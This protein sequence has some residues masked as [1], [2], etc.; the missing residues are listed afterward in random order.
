MK[1]LWNDQ[2]AAKF[3]GDL[4]LRVYTSRLLGRDKSLVLHGGGN[5]SV[6]IREKNLFGEQETILYVKGSGW[7]LET[8]EPQGFS[9]VLLA[10]VLRLAGL[11]SLSDP[12]MVNQLVTHMLKASAPAPSIETILHG[13]MPQKFVDHTHA[14]A[15]LSVSNT[16]DGE[17]RIREVYGKRCV[18]IPYLMPG[19]DLAQLCAKEFKRQSTPETVGMVLLN[20]GIFSFGETAREAYERM[21]ELV[22]LAEKYLESRGAWS[23]PLNPSSHSA[24]GAAAQ[25]GLRRRLSDAAC[26][27]LIVRTATNER[28][29]GLAAHPELARI[30]QQGPATP[31]HVIRTKR[32]PMLGTDIAAYV[33]EY[34]RYFNEHSPKAKEPKT[35]L[36]P[37]PRV[38]LDPAF[39]LAAAG[40]TAKDAAIVAEI[41]DHTIDVILRAEALGG[42]Q[43]LPAKDIFDV[44]YWDLEQ[45]KLKKGGTPPAFAGE[46]ALVTG[47]ASGIGK[48]TVAAFLARGAA[49]VG[50]DLNAGIES[51]HSRAD[52]LG[53]RCDV[54]DES[55]VRSALE[56]AVLAFGGLDM[57]VLNAGVF[58]ASRRIADLPTEEWRRAMTVN[59]DANLV[60]MRACHPFLKLAPRGGRVVVI[61]SKNVSAPGP[62]ASAYSASKAALNQLARIAALEWGADRIR[63]NTVHPNAVFDTGLWTEEVLVQRAKQY[64]MSVAAYK[65]NNVLGTEVTSRDVAELA[66]EMC[67]PL[68][69]KTT[70][71]QV[72][73]DGGNERV[74]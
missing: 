6:K 39:G 37:A 44:E 27:P 50:L 33:Q 49:V 16:K 29:L 22:T 21:I 20:H 4:G 71:A 56:R 41:Y 14:D 11:P 23:I 54:A 70:G 57:L 74:I 45:A 34:S 43:A 53:V 30:S 58:P 60:L 67:G 65:T 13:L 42:F 17:K 36:D 40:R 31:D 38:I 51:L 15:V 8:I 64:G 69:A 25:A 72:P 66:V 24:P 7:D 2:E 48:A 3:Q 9:P 19:F 32:T 1:S 10:H 35:I 68:F 47:A 28:T 55:Q 5:T 61:G 52:F 73:V 46:I 62:G 12:E 26:A 63:V 18:L 59:L